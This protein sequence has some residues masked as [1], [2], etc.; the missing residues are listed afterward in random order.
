MEED[1][2][3]LQPSP[4]VAASHCACLRDSHPGLLAFLSLKGIV[5]DLS[6]SQH[7]TDT[8]NHQMIT[9]LPNYQCV[10]IWATH[11]GFPIPALKIQEQG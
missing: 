8:E 2:H 4:S 5:E 7:S 6:T 11:P 1:K 10:V 9:T 3:S